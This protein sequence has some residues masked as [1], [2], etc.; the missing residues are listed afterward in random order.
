[1]ASPVVAGAVALML[2]AN[3]TATA[4][5]IKNFITSTATKDYFTER[6]TATPN[7]IY[8]FGKLDV[9]KAA[10]AM[11]N[12]LPTDRKQY[13]YDFSGTSAQS[14]GITLSVERVAVRF[15][16]DM[17][18]KLG[19]VNFHTS[20]TAT[21]LLVE[22]RTNK[23]GNPDSLLGSVSLDSASVARFS[24]NYFD[25]SGLNINV[26][27]GTGIQIQAFSLPITHAG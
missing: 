5:Q 25:L 18:G 11:F 22:V 13:Q 27:N 2:Q 1:M 23:N 7:P 4:S 16:P 3:P 26:T 9:Y 19:G 14:A 24:W 20:N 17:N 15:T 10:S 12:C 6:V 8:G 21:S